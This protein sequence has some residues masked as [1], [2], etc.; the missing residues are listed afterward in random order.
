MH[1]LVKDRAG[2]EAEEGRVRR[3]GTLVY[4]LFLTPL[5]LSLSSPLFVLYAKG[6]MHVTGDGGGGLVAVCCGGGD[7]VKGRSN[8]GYVRGDVFST[9]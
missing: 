4:T 6:A 7:G 1:H 2:A 8:V 9:W 3:V 5:S